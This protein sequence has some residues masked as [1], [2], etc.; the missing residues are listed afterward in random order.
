[1]GVPLR[2]ASMMILAVLATACRTGVPIASSAAPPPEVHGTIS[3]TV[4]GPGGTAPLVGR[5]VQAIAIDTGQVYETSTA[6]EG[7][8]T[9]EVPPGR[10]RLEV[11]LRDGERVVE[12]PEPTEVN[13][14]DVD[15]DRDFVVSSGGGPGA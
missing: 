1:M 6:A 15:D 3:G 5:T 8:Y 7:S 12:Q 11:E 2:T 4:R 9:I 13:P 14:S 10:Y